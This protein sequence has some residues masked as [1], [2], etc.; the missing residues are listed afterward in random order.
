MKAI[1]KWERYIGQSDSRSDD[2]GN[3]M[4]ADLIDGLKQKE[5]EKGEE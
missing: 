5:T 4:L 3:G 1:D 2:E